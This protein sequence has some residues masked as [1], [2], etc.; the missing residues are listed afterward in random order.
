MAESAGVIGESDLAS[1]MLDGEESFLQQILDSKYEK[2]DLL[3]VL[4]A[5]KHL[6]VDQRRLLEQTLLKHEMLFQGTLGEWPDL[7]VDIK[8]KSG[9][10]L[11]HCQKPFR[12]PHI[13][14]ETPKKEVERLVE[15]GM[16]KRASGDLDW[17]AQLHYSQERW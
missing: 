7:E 4:D 11:Y 15:I 17:A 9:S 16:L 8:L 1:G 12:I 6:T 2:Q 14:H 10:K 13:Y 3:A 5:Q